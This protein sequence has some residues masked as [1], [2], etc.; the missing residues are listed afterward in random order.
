M[1]VVGA[2]GCGDDNASTIA[3]GGGDP[4]AGGT[5]AFAGSSGSLPSGGAAA[6]VGGMST[7]ANQGGTVAGHGGLGAV[8]GS[9]NTTNSITGGAGGSKPSGA[10]SGG[11]GGGALT[12]KGEIGIVWAS[13]NPANYQNS[14]AYISKV[15]SYKPTRVTIVPTYFIDTY[16]DGIVTEWR[17]EKKVPDEATIKGILKEFLTKGYAVNYRPHVD[18]IKYAMLTGTERDNWSSDPGGKDW[19]GKFDK[20][21]PLSTTIKYREVMI[22]PG[23]KIVAEA[24]REVG[25]AKVKPVRFDLGAELM[26]SL[27]NYSAN[28]IKL[29]TEV[30]D[31]L[32]GE[33]KDVASKIRLSQNFCHHMEYLMTLPRHEEYLARIE[34]SGE[35][36]TESRYLDR[37]GVTDETRKQIGQ[38]IAGLDEFSLSQYMP[39]DIKATSPNETTPEQVRDALLEHESNYI[40]EVLIKT[41]GMKQSEIPPFH[42]GEFGIGILGI[43]APNVWDRA[44]WEKAGKSSEIPSDADQKKQAEAAI[45]G[46]ILYMKDSR[47]VAKSLMLWLGGKPYDVFPLNDYSQGWSNPGAVQ[48]LT[49]FWNGK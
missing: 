27:L 45:K 43:K 41:C 5:S 47:T 8:G 40:N 38:Y 26:D 10:G 16:A 48:A 35:V 36:N 22:R 2:Y 6:G 34:P 15:D 20:L 19:R 44:A 11:A 49:D 3:Q 17:G 14:S 9:G 29:Q 46:A 21:D 30:R 32:K 23:L 31:L 4:Y 12:G 42:I 18:P 24:I 13:Y 28:W 7:G 37:P 39:L 25:V 1:L 33:Y